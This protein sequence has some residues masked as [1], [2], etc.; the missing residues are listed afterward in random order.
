MF[1]SPRVLGLSGAAVALLSA[2]GGGGGGSAPAATT[3]PTSTGW[4]QG[5]FSPPATFAALCVTPRTGTDPV[6]MQPYPDRPNR[7]CNA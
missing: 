3:P 7:F 6:T 5:Q 2:C 1:I 4:V